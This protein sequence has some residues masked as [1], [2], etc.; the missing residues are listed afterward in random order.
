MR[1]LLGA[2]SRRVEHGGEIV[3]ERFEEPGAAALARE[4][5]PVRRIEDVSSPTPVRA[6]ERPCVLEVREDLARRA[7]G[8]GE[9]DRVVEVRRSTLLSR[10]ASA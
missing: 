10:S 6:I 4:L 3:V 7:R 8:G 2:R 5:E 1:G 9:A